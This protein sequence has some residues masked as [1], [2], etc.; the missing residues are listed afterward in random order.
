MGFAGEGMFFKQLFF[1]KV[2]AWVSFPLTGYIYRLV[3][4][5]FLA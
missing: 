5:M 1:W 4:L 3:D 2:L